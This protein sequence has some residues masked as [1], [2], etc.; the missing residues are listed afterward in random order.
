[1][2]SEAIREEV[3]YAVLQMYEVREFCDISD[4][5]DGVHAEVLRGSDDGAGSEHHG[6]GDGEARSGGHG[7][8]QD[9][10]GPRRI[11]GSPDASGALHP[12][13]RTGDKDGIPEA[14]SEAGRR[15]G[16]RVRAGR[17][18]GAGCRL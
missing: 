4:G 8:G 5:E 12:V 7:R 3:F 13:H 16:R 11:G 17:G 2:L 15:A 10:E 6:R 1:M 18:R 9:G 14:G